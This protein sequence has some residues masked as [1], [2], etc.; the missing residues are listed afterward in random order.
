LFPSKRLNVA[1]A[2]PYL[3]NWLSSYTLVKMGRTDLMSETKYKIYHVIHERGK[4]AVE[5]EHAKRA[6][7]WHRTKEAAIAR[8]RELASARRGQ[9]KVH[10][11]DGTLE[12][13][14]SYGRG[15]TLD[16][17]GPANKETNKAKRDAWTGLGGSI[18][19]IEAPSD[20]AE[21]HDYYLYG[22]PKRHIPK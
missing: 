1:K 3:Y 15:R 12:G 7:S 13:A 11:I 10:R 16:R 14:Y 4:W 21:E 6:S 5:G 9:L 18:G 20:W 8:G 17:N 19:T 22:T 2:L